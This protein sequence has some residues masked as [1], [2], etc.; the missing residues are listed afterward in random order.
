MAQIYLTAEVFSFSGIFE[1]ELILKFY[2]ILN[3]CF[4]PPSNGAVKA[5]FNEDG[6][7]S[8]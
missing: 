7:A 4:R 3:R 8:I 2:L 1:P 5:E 6:N